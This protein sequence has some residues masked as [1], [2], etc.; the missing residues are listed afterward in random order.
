MN[1]HND[2]DLQIGDL[3]LFVCLPVVMYYQAEYILLN[4]YKKYGT[5]IAYL[6]NGSAFL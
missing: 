3:K 5:T 6:R 1:S 2:L 4:H